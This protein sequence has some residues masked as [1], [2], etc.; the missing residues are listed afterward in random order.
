[1]R[2]KRSRFRLKRLIPAQAIIAP[3]SVQSDGR[4]K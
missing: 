2:G 4:G 3:L 1:M